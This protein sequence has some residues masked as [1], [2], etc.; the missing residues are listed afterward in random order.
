VSRLELGLGFQ[1][2][3]SI[4]AYTELARVG[5][6]MDF[7]VFSVYGDL[8]YQAALYPLL[9]MALHT[10]KVRL[11]PASLNP[12]TLHPVEIAGQIAALDQASRGRAFLGLARGSWLDRLGLQTHG[13]LSALR[14]TLEIVRRLLRGDTDGYSGERFSLSPGARLA[15]PTLRPDVPIMVGTW[16]RRTSGLAARMADEVK[17]GGSANPAMVRRMTDW[18]EPDL[19]RHGRAEDAVGVVMGAVTVVDRDGAAARRLGA[20]EVAMYL[21]V[22]LELDPTVDVPLGLVDAVRQHSREGDLAGAG[23]QI[24]ADI[25]D[26]FAFCGT[27]EQVCSQVED[28]ARVGTRRVDFGTPHG[29]TEIDGI[30][31]LGERVLPNFR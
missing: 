2:D 14:D 29:I 12:F 6:E 3:K 18:L 10:S 1:G 17:I 22:V 27:P 13:A 8:F 23:R 21:D 4:D 25:L 11:G 28:L 5:E 15:Y 9:V 19:R 20:M 16:S 7:D 31:L 24:P 30:R 26:R